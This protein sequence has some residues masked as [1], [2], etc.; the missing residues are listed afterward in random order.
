MNN[1]KIALTLLTRLGSASI[2]QDTS[3]AHA[4]VWFAMVGAILGFIYCSVIFTLHS[5]TATSTWAL[6]WIYISLDIWLTRAIHYDGLADVSDALGSAKQG[7][8]FWQ[9]MHDSRLGAFGALALFLALSIQLITINDLIQKEHWYVLFIA[10]I[11]GRILCV[12]FCNV[13]KARHANSLGGKVCTTLNKPLF[14]GY[15]LLNLILLWPLGF[16]MLLFIHFVGI[17]LFYTFINIAIKHGGC[18]G[19]FLGTLIVTGQCLLVLICSMR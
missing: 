1:F 4:R 11:F 17:L 13:V 5:L 10:P 15:L 18:N 12:L 7:D 3:L 2:V 14:V 16:F 19:D 9:V 6:A 8:A